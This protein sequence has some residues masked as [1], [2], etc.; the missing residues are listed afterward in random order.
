[1]H[2]APAPRA[3]LAVMTPS[4]NPRVAIYR[5]PVSGG[6]VTVWTDDR[7]PSPI[8]VWQMHNGAV[9]GTTVLFS[10]EAFREA[11]TS[12]GYEVAHA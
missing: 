7:S 4:D 11:I 6:L 8:A 5:N 2:S 9:I 3:P 12:T 10:L 1:M